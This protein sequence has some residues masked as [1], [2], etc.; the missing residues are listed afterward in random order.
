MA[1]LADV[2]IIRGSDMYASGDSIYSRTP[3]HLACLNGHTETATVLVKRG[4]DLEVSIM[5]ICAVS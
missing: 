5:M 2:L 3:L 4:A 1:E